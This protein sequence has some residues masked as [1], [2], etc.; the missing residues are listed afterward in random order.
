MAQFN[1]D[2]VMFAGN[3]ETIRFTGVYNETN[4]QLVS[5][6]DIIGASWGFTPYEDETIVLVNKDLVGEQIIV[7]EDG[8][9]IVQLNES[10][11][12]GLS[13]EFTHELRLR[14][15]GG[16]ITAARGRMTIKYQATN[17]PL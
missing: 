14:H 8:L 11:T 10:D 17:D 16:V 6:D 13:G 12:T 7:P 5:K 4:G 1:Q 15:S 9:V 3:D 2:F